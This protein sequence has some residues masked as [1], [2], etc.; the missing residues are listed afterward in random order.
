MAVFH[1]HCSAPRGMIFTALCKC[2]LT[3]LDTLDNCLN[4]T[5]AELC[6]FLAACSAKP[7]LLE[8]TCAMHS[9]IWLSKYIYMYIFFPCGEIYLFIYSLF[10]YLSSFPFTRALPDDLIHTALLVLVVYI[11]IYSCLL[12]Y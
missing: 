3:L 8:D 10:L 11:N 4:L 5:N 1:F 12:V 2:L 7:L 9:I 6:L